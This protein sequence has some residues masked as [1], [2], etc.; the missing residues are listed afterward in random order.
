M[1]GLFWEGQTYSHGS[2]VVKG[3]RF[4]IVNQEEGGVFPSS[5]WQ[6]NGEVHRGQTTVKDTK[7]G[8]VQSE[9]TK[10]RGESDH[11]EVR[12]NYLNHRMFPVPQDN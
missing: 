11:T 7:Q 10:G 8:L 12:D 9:D 5:G 2:D 6:L 4:A 3:T 1:L